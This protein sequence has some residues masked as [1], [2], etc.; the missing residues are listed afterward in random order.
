MNIIDEFKAFIALRHGI[1]QLPKGGALSLIDPS[2][3]GVL[4]T[5][6]GTTYAGVQNILPPQYSI[7]IGVGLSVLFLLYSFVLRLKGEAA[8]APIPGIP[9]V[10]PTQ[11]A[12]ITAAIEAKYP[13]LANIENAVKVAV[14][15]AKAA[16]PAVTI[17]LP[18]P[19]AG[20]SVTVS[21]TVAA[22]VVPP[23]AP[24]K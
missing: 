2:H 9:A 23:P 12:A 22:P 15:V 5:I 11:L 7:A 20:D 13:Q 24:A 19:A 3:I 10:D 14:E 4:L 21:T 6:L 1:S 18:P 17:P 16:A 8:P